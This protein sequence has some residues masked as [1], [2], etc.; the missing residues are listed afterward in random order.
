M[1]FLIP[2]CC[3]EVELCLDIIIIDLSTLSLMGP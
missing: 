3:A 2:L 1:P